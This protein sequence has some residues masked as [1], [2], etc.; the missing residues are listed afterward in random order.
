MEYSRQ[1]MRK[2]EKLIEY[3]GIIIATTMT[4]VKSIERIVLIFQQGDRITDLRTDPLLHC[5]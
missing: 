5:I 3:H 2:F 1:G 4:S